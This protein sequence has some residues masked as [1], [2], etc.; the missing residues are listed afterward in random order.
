MSGIS[1]RKNTMQRS[2][3]ISA[4]I[5]GI[6]SPLVLKGKLSSSSCSGQHNRHVPA[7]ELLLEHGAE[8]IYNYSLRVFLFSSLNA[9][10]NNLAHDTELLCV[11]SAFHDSA[12]YHITAALTIVLR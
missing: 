11:A 6:C 5:N 8:L 10:R 9:K 7:T 3:D 4:S 12:L 2:N 1:G